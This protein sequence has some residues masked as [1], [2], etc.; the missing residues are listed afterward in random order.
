MRGAERQQERLAGALAAAEEAGVSMSSPHS[1][2]P[3]PRQALSAGGLLAAAPRGPLPE[4]NMRRRRDASVRCFSLRRQVGAAE[5]RGAGRSKLLSWGLV[6]VST[7]LEPHGTQ[8]GHGIVAA[9]LCPA[10]RWH[11]TPLWGPGQKAELEEAGHVTERQ[12]SGGLVPTAGRA[13][14]SPS[15]L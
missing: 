6:C 9:A 1:G 3:G 13:A 5:T 7:S 12:K 14:H 10:L 2:L 4:Q 11:H 15:A 8:T